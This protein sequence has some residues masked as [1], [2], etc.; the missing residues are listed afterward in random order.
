MLH[1]HHRVSQPAQAAKNAQQP[2]VVSGVQSDARFVQHIECVH[3]RGA[4][5]RGQ[6]HPLDL[7]AREGPGLP[8]EG[9]VFEPHVLQVPKPAANLVGDH[10]GRL[11]DVVRF[12]GL[13]KVKS[14][15][16]VHGV[17]LCDG[18]P[19]Q[20]VQKGFGPKAGAVAVAAPVIPTVPGKKDPNRHFIRLGFQPV[21]KSANPVIGFGAFDN[22]PAL[23]RLEA[24]E[25]HVGGDLRLPAEIDQL[26]VLEPALG[27]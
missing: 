13:K 6:G 15:G 3:Q 1:H 12:H 24:G 23:S 19:G 27:H 10:P 17:N 4:Q 18:F 16:H 25:R 7:P 20:P 2:S 11:V 5:R 8:I 9:Q 21:E 26:T 14:V 22:R